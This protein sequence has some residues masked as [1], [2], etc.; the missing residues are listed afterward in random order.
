VE[1]VLLEFQWQHDLRRWQYQQLAR[2][3]LVPLGLADDRACVDGAQHPSGASFTNTFPVQAMGFANIN[4]FIVHWIDVPQTGNEACGSSNSFAVSLYDDGT[5][6]DENANQPLNPNN[7]IG[8][9]AVPFN[10]QEGP[11]DLRFKNIGGSIVGKFTRPDGSGYATFHYGR[12]DLIVSAA[13]PV[14]VGYSVGDQP[15][16]PTGLCTTADLGNFPNGNLI[17]NNS[18]ATIFEIFNSG[19]TAKPGFDLR[20]EGANRGL[21]T[22][23]GQHDLN[24]GLVRLLESTA[25]R[26]GNSP[27]RARAH[28]GKQPASRIRTGP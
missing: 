3:G 12:M 26:L 8:N 15:S 5:G 1:H 18:Q 24:R 22:P 16:S 27:A 21:S 9:N 11:T 2:D 17:G 28:H 23:V 7:P 4:H 14:L 20:F 10:L 13:N 19:T 25:I 6:V